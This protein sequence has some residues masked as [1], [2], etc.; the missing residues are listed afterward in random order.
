[1]FDIGQQAV[2]ETLGTPE[3]FPV[4][5]GDVALSPNGAW[6]VNGHTKTG[7]RPANYFT[8]FRR[9]D[10]IWTRTPGFDRGHYTGEL[11]IDPAPGWNRMGT[12]LLVGALADDA[13]RTRQLF[14]ITVLDND[15]K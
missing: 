9:A 6:F 3:I 10:G 1:M 12:Q 5:K 2:V 7:D 13:Q 8:L 4:P 11:R 15:R 14:V